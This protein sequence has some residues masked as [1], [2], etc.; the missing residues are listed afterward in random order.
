MVLAQPPETDAGKI[1]C[2]QLVYWENP[3]EATA[4]LVLPTGNEGYVTVPFHYQMGFYFRFISATFTLDGAVVD[5]VRD[6]AKLKGK[7]SIPI[8]AGPLSPGDHEVRLLLKMA[9]DGL[10]PMAYLR[11]YHFE[12]RSH[13]KFT[14]QPAQPLDI[15]IFA[16]E[17]SQPPTP[18]EERPAIC[19]VESPDNGTASDAGVDSQLGPTPAPAADANNPLE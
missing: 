15:H 6:D 3:H 5:E 16:Y 10:G 13:H 18:I 12:V 11:G 2:S 9:G 19:F 14:V 4:P 7:P 1:P 8:F 17:R